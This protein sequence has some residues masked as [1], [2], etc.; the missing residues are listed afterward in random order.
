MFTLLLMVLAQPDPRYLGGAAPHPLNRVGPVDE[1]P[2]VQACTVTTL[3][4]RTPCSFEGTPPDAPDAARQAEAN[5]KLVLAL[6]DALCRERAAA[7]GTAARDRD[8]RARICM[9]RVRALAPA[10]A[11]DGEASLL[12]AS[13]AFSP[14]AKDCYLELA[15][16]TQLA[17]VPEPPPE[18]G[19]P[20][21]IPPSGPPTVVIPPPPS[22]RRL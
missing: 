18:P 22:V 3:R 7:A 21:A 13:G 20:P 19:E 17:A 2:S 9:D 8:A 4:Q 14:R 10:C 1:S 16:A 5:V 15:G 12:D 6:G 11:V